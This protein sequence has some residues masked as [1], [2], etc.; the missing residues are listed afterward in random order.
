M[1]GEVCMGVSR[2]LSLYGV[3]V[4]L[5][6]NLTGCKVWPGEELAPKSVADRQFLW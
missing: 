3:S 2:A 4:N 6:N 5:G 1:F